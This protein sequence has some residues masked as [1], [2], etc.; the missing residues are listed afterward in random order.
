MSQ[1]GFSLYMDM[2]DEAV[3][4]LKAGKE[5]SLENITAKQTEVDLKIAAL[6]PD[7]YIF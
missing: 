6:I 5:L 1:V 7:D 2:L 4:A 3:K